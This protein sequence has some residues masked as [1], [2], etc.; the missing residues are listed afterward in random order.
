MKGIL[1]KCQLLLAY[2]LLELMM[3][4]IPKDSDE[5]LELIRAIRDFCA[6]STQ[7]TAGRN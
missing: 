5:G 1:R 4:I 3:T 7:R 2:N 6:D